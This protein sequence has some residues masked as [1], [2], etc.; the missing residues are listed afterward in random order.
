MVCGFGD[1][2]CIVLTIGEFI[3]ALPA[4][5]VVLRGR[6][7][8]PRTVVLSARCRGNGKRLV[9][10]LRTRPTVFERLERRRAGI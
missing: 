4:F 5:S 9:G 1:P 2:L 8:I 6:C 7:S 3:E 10:R